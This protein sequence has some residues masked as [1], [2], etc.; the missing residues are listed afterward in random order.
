LGASV[1]PTI[2]SVWVGPTFAAG[3]GAGVGVVTTLAD[4][5]AGD[6]VVVALVEAG[7]GDGVAA[8]GA[9]ASLLSVAGPRTG[10]TATVGVPARP[11]TTTGAAV[12]AVGTTGDGAITL[13][14]GTGRRPAGVTA[15]AVTLIGGVT[16]AGAGATITGL[17]R[18]PGGGGAPVPLSGF[19]NRSVIRSLSPIAS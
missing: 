4:G 7:F 8:L 10:F 12:A 13:G 18:V 6:N 1:G 15:R 16:M 3:A 11:G 14:T 17:H 9:V 2:V 19:R 5:A